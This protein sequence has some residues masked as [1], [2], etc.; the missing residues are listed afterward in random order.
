MTCLIGLDELVD[1]RL[2]LVVCAV[3]GNGAGPPQPANAAQA[4][5]K[6]KK[7]PARAHIIAC[8]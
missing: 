8:P 2:K 1:S 3:A 6:N 4:T 5:A 7:R